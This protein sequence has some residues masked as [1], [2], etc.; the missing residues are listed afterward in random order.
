MALPDKSTR[1]TPEAVKQL[2]DGLTALI[3]DHP[4][5]DDPCSFYGEIDK[6]LGPWGSDGYPIG[7]GLF[8]CKLF[9]NDPAL[10]RDK[11]AAEWVK[12]TRIRL[13]EFLRDFIVA[14]F[15]SNRL[16][17]LTEANLREA[18]FDS[19]PR[20][21]EEAGLRRVVQLRPALVPVIMAIPR[22]EFD[23]DNPSFGATMKQV[24]V[25]G[26]GVGL[27][28]AGRF[29]IS[30]LN[31]GEDE[32]L[33]LMR[34]PGNLDALHEAIERGRVDDVSLLGEI[35]EFVKSR[36]YPDS[37][38][39]LKATNV[40]QA[41]EHRI[42]RIKH[43]YSLLLKQSPSAAPEIKALLGDLCWGGFYACSVLP[44]T[45]DSSSSRQGGEKVGR[46]TP[47]RSPGPAGSPR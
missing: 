39:R 4:G 45:R 30:P 28:M 35:I 17:T 34:L 29:V 20:A 31:E 21:Y 23:Y 1:V 7:Y 18:A 9:G 37:E 12:K 11:I 8:Y 46:G 27:D 26:L 25:T 16:G 22:K 6:Y 44:A 13:Q 47:L 36:A 19:H 43:Y 14:E 10:Q 38:T 32:S 42:E 15:R 24:V 41:A 33:R 3:A 40:V 5:V 2:H